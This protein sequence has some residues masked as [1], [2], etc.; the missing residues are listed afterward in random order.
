MIEF[1]DLQAIIPR[2][3]DTAE[4]GLHMRWNQ[5]PVKL[6]DSEIYEAVGGL[7]ARQA[8]LSIQF[9]SSPLVWN[10]HIAPTIM[11]CMMDALITVKWILKDPETRARKYV[12]YG[13]GQQ[14]LYIENMQA[15]DD[16]ED[17]AIAN[18]V[19]RMKEWLSSQRRDALT[20]VNVGSWS[21]VTT[22]KMAQEC[23][24]DDLYKFDYTQFSGA[25]H[26]MW[27]HVSCFNLK[28]CVNPLHNLHKVPTI[29]EC[30][31]DLS[32]MVQSADHLEQ[33]YVAVDEAYDL[34]IEVPLP[35]SFLVGEFDKIDQ[36]S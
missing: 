2:Y 30:P 10:A 32:F 6:Y 11:R 7:M 16:A 36:K 8:T 34:Q 18:L 21:E 19:C 22:R 9:A 17:P 12:L 24:L 14:K 33:C 15:R 20:E 31:I 35:R 29:A 23:G 27:H 13:L 28:S 3:V 25:A 1:S 26:N 4:A 5:M